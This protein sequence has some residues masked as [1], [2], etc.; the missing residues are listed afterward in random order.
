M[1][2][3]EAIMWIKTLQEDAIFEVNEA[4]LLAIEALSEWIPKVSVDRPHG[5]WVEVVDRTEQ[6]DREGVKTWATLY[7]CSNC[8]FV[9]N[10]IEGHIGQYDF[11]PNCG[12]DMRKEKE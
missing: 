2:R 9:L 10:A 5:E 7:Q 12:A 6:Y 1:T 11:C 3:E 8:G 4:L